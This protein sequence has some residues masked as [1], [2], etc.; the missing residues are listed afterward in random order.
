MALPTK[1]YMYDNWLD[2]TLYPIKDHK[3]AFGRTS[4]SYV[5]WGQLRKQ[6]KSPHTE[7]LYCYTLTG[8]HDGK[9]LVLRSINNCTN[10]ELQD[11]IKLCALR[12]QEGKITHLEAE[13]ILDLCYAQ[14]Q[15]RLEWTEKSR[16]KSQKHEDQAPVD[17]ST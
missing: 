2:G 1:V 11:A 8:L 6:K 14:L 13:K 12:L 10:N 15:Q 7:V 16:G 9:F 5:G 17:T 3:S 4:E